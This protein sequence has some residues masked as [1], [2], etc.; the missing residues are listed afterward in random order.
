MEQV[1]PLTPA[2]VAQSMKSQFFDC[3]SLNKGSTQEGV[4]WNLIQL[5]QIDGNQTVSNRI[6]AELRP[7]YEVNEKTNS[8]PEKQPLARCG[9]KQTRRWRDMGSEMR[10]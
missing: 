9:R 2:T 3:E 7:F 4:I 5:S 10:S 1:D 6:L 8:N